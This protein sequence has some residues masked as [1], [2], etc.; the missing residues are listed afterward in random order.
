M[1]T[2]NDSQPG[3][4]P[5]PGVMISDDAVRAAAPS[6]E[7]SQ[8]PGFKVVD[9]VP[10]KGGTKLVW[11]AFAVVVVILAGFYFGFYR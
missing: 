8:Q 7:A 5:S 9:D 1:G 3:E 4:N 2:V 6:Q 11:T 10:S